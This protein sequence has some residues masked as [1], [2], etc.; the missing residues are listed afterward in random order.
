MT[1]LSIVEFA[2]RI[3][4]IMPLITKEFARR[5]LKELYKD[6]ITISQFLILEFLNK[7]GSSNMSFLAHFMNVTT[8]AMTGIIDRLV[9]DGYARRVY[10]PKDRRIIKIEL[11]GRGNELVKKLHQ[12]RRKMII[13]IFGEI[14]ERDRRDYLRI[15]MQIKEVL[16]RKGK[17]ANI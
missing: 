1:E 10:D 8:A 16:S 7:E 13:R 15:L 4:Q 12:E 17:E 14:S 9:R 6:K 3:S 2:D 5:Q 11:T